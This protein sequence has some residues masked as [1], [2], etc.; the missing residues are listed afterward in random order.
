MEHLYIQTLKWMDFQ[1]ARLASQVPPPARVNRDG[2]CA[3]DYIEKS[4][5]QAIVQK[6]ARVISGLKAS[7]LLLELGYLQEQAALC[8]MINEFE[9]DIR[10]LSIA[11]GLSPAPT[12]LKRYLDAFFSE[13]DPVAALRAGSRVKGQ[14]LVGRKDIVN[15]FAVNS[16]NAVDQFKSSNTALA[17]GFV[18]SGYVHGMSRH[19]MEMYNPATDRFDPG[20]SVGHPLH[21]DHQHDIWNY[22]YRAI[23][24]FIWAAVAFND[25]VL[26]DAT[27]F[28]D[29]QFKSLSGDRVDF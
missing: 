29:S 28:Q 12:L 11:S 7:L 19:I 6:I 15:F 10:F 2:A 5:Q 21:S 16:G 13:T 27:K 23:L 14:N 18:F 4:A 20:P 25:Q 3:Y 8:R 17:I 24:M 9:E 1:L 22:F 26:L